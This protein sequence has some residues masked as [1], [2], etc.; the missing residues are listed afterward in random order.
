MGPSTIIPIV[1]GILG[2]VLLGGASHLVNGC[3]WL[4]P[5]IYGIFALDYSIWEYKGYMEV[6]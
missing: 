4:F 3:K 1:E 2:C 6:S 5:V